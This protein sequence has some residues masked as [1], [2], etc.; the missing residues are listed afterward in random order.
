MS[1]QSQYATFLQQ[2]L[3]ERFEPVDR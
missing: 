2:L 3:A 1:F